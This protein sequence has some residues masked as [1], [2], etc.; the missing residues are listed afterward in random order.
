MIGVRYNTLGPAVIFELHIY[1]VVSEG[2]Y[3]GVREY[4]IPG[5]LRP[6]HGL[7]IDADRRCISAMISWLGIVSVLLFTSASYLLS[8]IVG[9]DLFLSR[10]YLST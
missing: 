6:V 10:F 3:Y 2:A 7:M 4:G 9:T 8:P 1:E 5:V